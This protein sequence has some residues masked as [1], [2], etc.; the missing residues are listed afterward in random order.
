MEEIR[1]GSCGRKLGTGTFTEL[2]IKCGRCKAM[3][4]LRVS[5]SLSAHHEC[6]SMDNTREKTNIRE[7]RARSN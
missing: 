4:I 7:F 2:H 1:C 5:N 6:H 3:N